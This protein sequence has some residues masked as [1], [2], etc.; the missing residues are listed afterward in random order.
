MGKPPHIAVL[1]QRI[2]F[3]YTCFQNNSYRV[4]SANEEMQQEDINRLYEEPALS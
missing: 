1:K 3:S 2:T 4:T